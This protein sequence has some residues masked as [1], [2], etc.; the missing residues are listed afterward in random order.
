MITVPLVTNSIHIEPSSSQDAKH[1]LFCFILNVSQ[2]VVFPGIAAS[3]CPR[4]ART[5]HVGIDRITSTVTLRTKPTQV[6]LSRSLD[7]KYAIVYF[8]LT[9]SQKVVFPGTATSACARSACTIYVGIHR[10][11]ITA[12]LGTKPTRVEPSLSLGAK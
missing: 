10:I 8:I 3:A 11:M 1:A 5:F 4:S 9:V 6:E 12:R 7:V 2:K